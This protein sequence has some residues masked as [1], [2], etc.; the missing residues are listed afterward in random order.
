MTLD[1]IAKVQALSPKQLLLPHY[2]IVTGQEAVQ[3]LSQSAEVTRKT[4]QLILDLLHQGNS[5]E[6]IF[7]RLTEWLYIEPVRPYYP[8]AAYRMNTMIMIHLI[9]KE[10]TD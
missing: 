2:G 3:F 6:E 1:S 9:Q 7:D 5:T 8:Y 4:A 10:C